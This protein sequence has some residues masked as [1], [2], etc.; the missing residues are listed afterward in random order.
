[1][2]LFVYGTLLS[3]IPSSMSKFLRRR[4]TLIGKATTAGNLYDLGSYPGFVAGGEATVKGELY[5]L[6]PDRQQQTMDMLDAYES[7]TGEADDQYRR[8]TIQVL[9]GGGGT[10]TAETYAFLGDTAGLP[11]IPRG[12]YP[13][14]YQGKTEHERFVNGE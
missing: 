1:M 4:S 9:V 13:A 14:Y 2:Y 7:V 6:D 3:N 12:D 8:V 11:H 5:R 10:F